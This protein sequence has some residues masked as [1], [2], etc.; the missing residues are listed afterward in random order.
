M[1]SLDQGERNSAANRTNLGPGEGDQAEK[2]LKV[3]LWAIEK[4]HPRHLRKNDQVV[5]RMIAAIREFSFKIPILVRRNGEVIDGCLRLKEAQKLGMTKLPV[6][7]CDEWSESQ[8]RA[9]RLLANRS[10]TWADWDTE[11]VALEIKDPQAMDFD[12]SLT[13]FDPIEIDDLLL[14][15]EVN[16][17]EEDIPEPYQDI[18]TEIGDLWICGSHRA[19]CGDATSEAAV[20]HLLRAAAPTLMVSDPPYGV[21]LDPQWRERAT[22]AANGRRPRFPTMTG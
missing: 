17:A 12:L 15:D 14:G 16:S 9:F 22:L 18:V 2:S 10:V 19:L 3:E 5:D 21:S 20:R 1:N 8:V 7:V 11:L 6:L 4:P 13:G